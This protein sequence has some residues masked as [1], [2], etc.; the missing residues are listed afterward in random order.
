MLFRVKPAVIAVSKASAF[1]LVSALL[2]L[3]FGTLVLFGCVRLYGDILHTQQKQQVLMRLQQ[4]AHQLLDYLRQ[5]V[6]NAGFQGR[7]R[8]D[9]N[10]SLFLD[11]RTPYL[12]EKQCLI[13]LSDLNADGCLGSRTK[14]QC[15]NGQ[16]SVANEVG[17][18]IVALKAE[19]GQL[20]VLGK[21]ESFSPCQPQHCRRLLNGCEQLQWD[22]LSNTPDNRIDTFELRW[23]KP[24]ELLEIQLVLSAVSQPNIRYESTAQIYLLNGGSK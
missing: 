1:S 4:N 23:L 21:Y 10:F 19:A 5:A 9:S 3:S 22:K 15:T 12:V 24:N 6:Q 13:V 17:R 7:N 8:S 20:F 11:G 16:I 18:E 14:K 2:A